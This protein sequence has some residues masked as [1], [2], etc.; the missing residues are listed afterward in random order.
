MNKFIILLL[1]CL[2][3]NFSFADS[4]GFKY[5][6]APFNDEDTFGEYD[7]S[8][9]Y[10][11]T[12]NKNTGEDTYESAYI[13]FGE[14]EQLFDSFS[15]GLSQLQAEYLF[16][17]VG[18]NFDFGYGTRYIAKSSIFLDSFG[19]ASANEYADLFLIFYVG[20]SKALTDTAGIY[21]GFTLAPI[22]F[23]IDSS[24][25]NEDFGD[26][27]PSEHYNYEAGIYTLVG[28]YSV[29]LGYRY[30]DYY[31][32]DYDYNQGGFTFSVSRG[33]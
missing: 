32:A 20:T 18:E 3:A 15:Y 13:L 30:L 24:Y 16:G 22:G 19:G 9:I 7:P 6:D 27:S 23:I 5:W 26:S 10:G 31:G 33:L 21:A 4:I 2:F 8:S 25:S 17:K 1:T 29:N 28:E 12:Y 11:L 14:Y